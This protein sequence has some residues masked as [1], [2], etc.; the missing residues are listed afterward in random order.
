MYP[1]RKHSL[2]VLKHTIIFWTIILQKDEYQQKVVMTSGVCK[3]TD[4]KVEVNFPAEIHSELQ[5]VPEIV[6]LLAVSVSAATHNRTHIKTHVC[7]E[8]LTESWRRNIQTFSPAVSQR[9][10]PNEANSF[11]HSRGVCSLSDHS[12]A[13]AAAFPQLSSNSTTSSNNHHHHIHV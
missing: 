11:L 9:V 5:V 7:I 3:V 6:K 8:P 12:A 2:S 4:V 10:E 1:W 13:V